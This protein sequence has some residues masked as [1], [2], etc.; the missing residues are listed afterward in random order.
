M[1]WGSTSD[2]EKNKELQKEGHRIASGT[3]TRFTTSTPNV[4]DATQWGEVGDLQRCHQKG[5]FLDYGH[6]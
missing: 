1:L 2:H 4:V 5:H 3:I 6:R